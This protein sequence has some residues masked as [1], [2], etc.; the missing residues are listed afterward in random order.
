MSEKTTDEF[1]QAEDKFKLN[2]VWKMSQIAFAMEQKAFVSPPRKMVIVIARTT[3]VQLLQ[4]A[5][6]LPPVAPATALG[7]ILHIQARQRFDD[8]GVVQI[9]GSP[10]RVSM[11]T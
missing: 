1:T 2:I 10:R 3:C 6:K 9:V 4:T 11:S 5:D 7:Q 8:V